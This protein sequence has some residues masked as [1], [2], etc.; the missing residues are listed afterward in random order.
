MQRRGGRRR[1]RADYRAFSLWGS[2]FQIDNDVGLG[3]Q[4]GDF[5]MKR[6]F[7]SEINDRYDSLSF[8]V[9]V[10]PGFQRQPGLDARARWRDERF[11]AARRTGGSRDFGS[12]PTTKP[13]ASC[14]I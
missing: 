14:F 5:H 10:V 4:P 13:K 11:R 12:D 1:L 3:D 9:V 6:C 7:P 8:F 2:I